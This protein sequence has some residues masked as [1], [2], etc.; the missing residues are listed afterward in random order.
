MKIK[1]KIEN[2]GNITITNYTVGSNKEVIIPEK[3]E[4]KPVTIIL[5]Y[6]YCLNELTK[7]QIPNSVTYIGGNAFAEDKLTEIQISNSVIEIGDYAFCNNEL[8]SI[9]IPNSVTKIGE[10]AFFGN[11]LTSVQ[12]PNSVILIED[13]A[14]AVNKELLQC[15]KLTNIVIPDKFKTEE[16]IQSIFGFRLNELHRRNREFVRPHLVNTLSFHRG[17]S[18]MIVDYIVPSNELILELLECNK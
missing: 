8:T 1:Y 9:Q 18:D 12:I 4:G 2:S 6:V 11:E 3:I 15:N 7:V 5:K 16:Q 10:C 17:L 13:D 14:F